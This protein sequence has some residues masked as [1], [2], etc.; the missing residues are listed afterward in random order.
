MDLCAEYTGQSACIF[1]RKTEALTTKLTTYWLDVLGRRWTIRC[2]NPA[3]QRQFR[4]P[5]TDLDTAP[6]APQPQGAGSIPVRVGSRPSAR[7]HSVVL[8]EFAHDVA[9][10]LRVAVGAGGKR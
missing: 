6:S 1:G 10:G 9:D 2:Q 5:W 7:A 8:G 3:I 4:Q